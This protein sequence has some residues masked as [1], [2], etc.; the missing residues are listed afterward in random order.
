MVRRCSV[1]GV[2]LLAALTGSAGLASCRAFGAPDP[3]AGATDAA[4]DSPDAASGGYCE[5][6]VA[7]PGRFCEDFDDAPPFDGW[8]LDGAEGSVSA[9]PSHEGKALVAS[10]DPG[11]SA[12]VTAKLTR[13]FAALPTSLAADLRIDPVLSASGTFVDVIVLHAFDKAALKFWLR[14]RADAGTVRLELVDAGSNVRGSRDLPLGDGSTP[15]R[16]RVELVKASPLQVSAFVNNQ[17]VLEYAE[18]T[19]NA[20]LIVRTELDLGAVRDHRPVAAR[21]TA[22][23]DNVVVDP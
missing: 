11:V 5:R 9:I 7:V 8:T 4:A 14:V 13:S 1:A 20:A 19:A 6:Q 2:T 23:I 18:L 16:L 21:F 12:P 22:T 15:A 17:R 3:S 10:L